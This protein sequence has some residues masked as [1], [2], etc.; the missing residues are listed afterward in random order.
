MS[1][2]VLPYSRFQ[3]NNPKFRTG[4]VSERHIGTEVM[5]CRDSKRICISSTLIVTVHD[6][7]S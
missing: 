5:N 6:R 7:V 3:S 2:D 4:K 1:R